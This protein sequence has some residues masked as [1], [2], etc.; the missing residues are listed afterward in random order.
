MLDYLGFEADL[1]ET[2]QMIR[3]TAREFLQTEVAEDIGELWIDGTLP[4]NLMP[5][6]GEPGF[7]GGNLIEQGL[8]Y[9]SERAYG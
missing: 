5:A 2:D 4:K 1:D 3:D 8:P 9:I 6:M 7:F